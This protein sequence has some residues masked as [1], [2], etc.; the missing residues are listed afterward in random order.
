MRHDMPTIIHTYTRKIITTLTTTITNTMRAAA[1]KSRGVLGRGSRKK[2]EARAFAGGAGDE[3][4]G[5]G[6][7][8]TQTM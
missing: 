8:R 5:V 2:K 4:V 7:A 3:M 6:V 1:A